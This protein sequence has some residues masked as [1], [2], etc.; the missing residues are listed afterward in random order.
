MVKGKQL[1]VV[2]HVDDLKISHADPAVVG[3]LI[4]ELNKRY[5]TVRINLT[6][7]GIEH[8]DNHATSIF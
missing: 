7:W 8:P 3:G 2:W 1:T 6:Y 5:G 4:E